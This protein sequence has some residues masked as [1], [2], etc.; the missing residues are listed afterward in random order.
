MHFCN[1]F[2]SR[3]SIFICIFPIKLDIRK[4]NLHFSFKQILTVT[5][6]IKMKLVKIFLRNGIIDSLVSPT[7]GRITRPSQ[8]QIYNSVWVVLSKNVPSKI[9]R[10]PL[11]RA[12]W[13]GWKNGPRDLL[14]PVRL[15]Q[16]WKAIKRSIIGPP[17]FY[18]RFSK[19]RKNSR[20]G[21]I[22]EVLWA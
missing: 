13:K 16:D 19:L 14:N 2:L 12:G 8:S 11:A 15:G 3:K 17:P 21:G 20:Q 1:L 9:N 4:E 10:D 5:D 7:N 6:F 18:I 22:P